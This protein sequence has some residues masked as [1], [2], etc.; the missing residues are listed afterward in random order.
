MTARDA[1][2]KV[3]TVRGPVAQQ[4]LGM[5]LTHE[6]L[7]IDLSVVFVDPGDQKGRRL[8]EEKVGLGNLGWIRVN[9]SSNRDNLVQTDVDLATREAARFRD[10]GGGTIVDATSIGIHRNPQA[11]GKIS[12]EAGSH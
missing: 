1:M 10:A 9:W 6:H 12:P 7:L 11:R 2:G 4:D 3:L 5:T 8:A